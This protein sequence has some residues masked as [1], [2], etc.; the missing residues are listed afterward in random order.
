MREIGRGGDILFHQITAHTCGWAGIRAVYPHPV[1][2]PADA[3][4]RAPWPGAGR[5]WHPEAG[6]VHLTVHHNRELAH[7]IAVVYAIQWAGQSDWKRRQ[8]A[9]HYTPFKFV[10]NSPIIE[11]QNLGSHCLFRKSDEVME[12]AFLEPVSYFMIMLRPNHKIIAVHFFWSTYLAVMKISP[13][14]ASC[15]WSCICH[16]KR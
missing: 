5:A 15:C 10:K 7:W 11:L 6:L 1:R 4:W 12:H 2:P 9:N 14:H 13:M 16:T 3:L 8:G